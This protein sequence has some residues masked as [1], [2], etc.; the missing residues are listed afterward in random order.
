[1]SK[2]HNV[3]MG[4]LQS[5]IS[6]LN[7]ANGVNG[8]GVLAI[9]AFLGVIKPGKQRI[10]DNEWKRVIDALDRILPSWRGYKPPQGRYFQFKQEGR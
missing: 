6:D 2:L 10:T 3:G 8:Q 1:M 4:E 7:F 9:G 5:L